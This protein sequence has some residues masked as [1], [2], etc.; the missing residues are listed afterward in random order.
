VRGVRGGGAAR[1]PAFIA[2]D[3]GG[4][5]AVVAVCDDELPA[6][7]FPAEAFRCFAVRHGPEPVGH[8][9]VVADFGDR[10]NLADLLEQRI[11]AAF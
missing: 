11:D 2:V 10:W 4:L 9:I 6:R 3:Q 5:I 1:S 7:H 8:A